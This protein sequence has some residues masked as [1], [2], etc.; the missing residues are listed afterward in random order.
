M[1]QPSSAIGVA[2]DV[3]DDLFV[4]PVKPGTRTLEEISG[5]ITT[6]AETLRAGG[7]EALK[8]APVAITIT[9]LGGTGVETFQAIISPPQAAVLAIGKIAPAVCAEGD[10]VVVRP[11]VTL[12]LSADHR[13]VNGKYAA[14]FLRCIVDQLESIGETHHD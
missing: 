14:S 1:P 2:V 8:L 3:N 12:T 10:Q 7:P 11:R 6:A 4:V 9:N 13:I 5:E